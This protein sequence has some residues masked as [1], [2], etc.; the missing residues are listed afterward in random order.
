[1]APG[2]LCGATFECIYTC[3]LA[4]CLVCMGYR[5][6]FFFRSSDKMTAAEGVPRKGFFKCAACYRAGTYCTHMSS[7]KKSKDLGEE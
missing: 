4:L 3:G 6:E 5:E 2:V 7:S 1:M